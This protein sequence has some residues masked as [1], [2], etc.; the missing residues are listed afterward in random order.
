MDMQRLMD[1]ITTAGR[2]SR[3]R[4]HLS[5]GQLHDLCGAF[6][7]ALV[8]VDGEHGLGTEHSYR[9]YYED[10]CFE[11]APDPVPSQD[12][13]AACQRALSQTYEGYKGGDF[14][15]AEDTSLWV[16]HY[17][18]TGRALVAGEYRD[19]AIHLTTKEIGW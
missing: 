14:R 11:P 10:L 19:G 6:P 18:C 5:L 15:Y 12:V 4:Y 7:E 9:G 3:K 8:I 13:F 1:A 17:G 2:E 16:A